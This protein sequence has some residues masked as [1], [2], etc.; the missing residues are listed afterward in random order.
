MSGARVPPGY[1]GPA[2]AP[3]IVGR[4]AASATPLAWSDAAAFL[5]GRAHKNVVLNTSRM[6]TTTGGGTKTYYFGYVRSRGAQA[7]RIVLELNTYSVAN[8][9]TAKVSLTLTGAT[10]LAGTNTA[11]L[12][13]TTELACPTSR[14]RRVEEYERYFD[15][16]GLTVG[17]LNWIA[18]TV[19]AGVYT[20]RGLYRLSAYEVPRPALDPASNPS[21]DPGLNPA[22]GL[23]RGDVFAGSGSTAADAGAGMERV[24]HQLDSARSEGHR[25]VLSLC[26][27]EDT[28]DCWSDI[29]AA[30]PRTFQ[31]YTSG[32]I[33]TFRVR[34]RR[35][36]TSATT[37]ACKIAIRYNLNHASGGT[38]HVY[39]GGTTNVTLANTAGAWAV[40]TGS[41]AIETNGG[42]QEM[43]IQFG[44]TVPIGATL[45]VSSILIYD[46][47][48]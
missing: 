7:L 38:W 28:T 3:C 35:L 16:S 36:Y 26:T 9:S 29:G 15:V 18:V 34:V 42:D 1:H 20:H 44:S 2:L 22:W 10:V 43:A 48:S 25:T 47:E 45:Y 37:N 30:G 40:A 31:M 8:P 12:D 11:P 41:L 46:Q 5:A 32:Y 4:P 6:V 17:A 24:L 21:T 23:P 39:T 27:V 33:P 13:G 19:A 14:L